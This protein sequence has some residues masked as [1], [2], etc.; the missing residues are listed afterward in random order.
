MR[1]PALL[2]VAV[3]HAEQPY[4]IRTVAGAD[5]VRDGGS[6]QQAILDTAMGLALDGAGNLF[7]ADARANR[8]RRV[9]PDRSQAQVEPMYAYG[10][11]ETVAGVGAPYF[12]GDGGPAS[13]AH[14]SSPSAMAFGPDGALYVGDAGN[15]RIRKITSDGVIVTISGTGLFSPTG[16]VGPALSTPI[17]PAAAL[18]VDPAGNIYFSD[19]QP[20]GRL[21]RISADGQ[22]TTYGGLGRR[23][24]EADGGPATDAE[25]LMPRALALDPAGN[26]YVAETGRHAVRKIAPDGTITTVAG[27][28]T[29][30]SSGDGGPARQAALSSPRLLA[31]DAEGAL[32]IGDNGN[33]AL[34]RVSP[35]GI[36]STVVA[37][38]PLNPVAMAVDPAGVLFLSFGAQINLWKP[39][40]TAFGAPVV[41]DSH[42]SA[43]GVPATESLVFAPQAV[44]VDPS[45]STLYIAQASGDRLRRVDATGVIGTL[46]TELEVFLPADLAV[47]SVGNLYVADSGANQVRRLTRDGAMQTVAGDGRLGNSGDGGPAT[48]AQITS[49][50]GVDVDAAG[51]LYIL[52]S[53]NHRIR[54]VTPDGTITA[55]AGTGVWGLSGDGG[56]AL[57]AQ[58]NSPSGLAVDRK[59]GAVYVLDQGGLRVR[60]IDAEGVITTF[61]TAATS[62]RAIALDLDGT[63]LACM[64]HRILRLSRTAELLA[65]DQ[66]PGYAGDGGPA[67]DARL[68]TPVDL[69]VD[70]RGAIYVADSGNHR[71]RK[72]E[73]VVDSKVEVFPAARRSRMTPL[74]TN[75]P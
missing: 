57:S 37:P 54:K 62:I 15:W 64:G 14:L 35:A 28:G 3:L 6:A 32:Y 67:V 66:I 53:I 69:S 68:N 44:A 16:A 43:D 45:T 23:G 36:I 65:G 50:R 26:L 25:L 27:T 75:Y 59:S 20:T 60:R 9:T 19:G 1:L 10:S 51:H 70:S 71:I 33:R 48:Q 11:I 17:L 7:I 21:C 49:P 73:P 30:G 18:A 31:M 8:V 38:L 40:D 56:P 29:A 4:T 39:A 24:L 61:G 74:G 58:F 41:G 52:D 46:A 34:R 22:L 12:S 2:L 72:L 47:D 13:Q 55:F 63:L 5:A 42:R